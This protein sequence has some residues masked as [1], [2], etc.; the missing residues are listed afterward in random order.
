M[1]VLSSLKVRWLGSALTGAAFLSGFMAAA[2]ATAQQ[3]VAAVDTV[4]L[5]GSEGIETVTVTARRK[6][7]NEHNVPISLTALEANT[8]Q[9]NG[10]ANA[11]KLTELV[12]SLQ[13]VS[14]NARNTNISV[15][16]L[17]SNI[18]LANDGIEGGV[19][20]YV[21]G[22]FYPR[23][24]EATFDFPDI[25]S[26]EEL[27]GP[28]G[29]LYGKNTT[30]GA[31]NITTLAPTVD[32]EFLGSASV[33]DWSYGKIDGTVSGS[34]S[35]DDTLLGR[36]TA[37]ETTRNG[38]LQNVTTGSRSFDY[39]DYGLRGQTVWQPNSDFKL[40]IIADY[41]KQRQECCITVLQNFVSTLDDGQAVPWNFYQR[42]A[43]AGYTPLPIDPFARKTD[44]N[45][46]YHEFMEQGGLSA[47][48]DWTRNGYTFTSISAFRF[49]NWNPD[50][51]SDIT[52]LSV[53]DTARQA[54]QEDEF[55]QEFR[56]QSPTSDVFEY[57]AG[58]YYFWE[59]D[60]GSG[61]QIYGN[62]APVWLVHTSTDQDW[63]YALQNVGIFSKSDPR[64]NSY[65]AYGQAVWHVTPNI[66]LTGGVRYT[67]EEKTGS[68][69]QNVGGGVDISTL[70]PDEQATILAHRAA[71][72][73]VAFPYYQVR[74]D[75][76]E[77]SGLVT[78]SYKFDDDL[79]AYATYSH[80]AKSGGL[81]LS[82]LPPGV[83]NVVQP[84][85]E[86]N[87]E[88]GF[89]SILLDH[90][91]VLNADAFWDEDTDYQATII[92][93]VN[94]II[95]NYIS[96]IPSVRSRGLEADLHAQVTEDL[97]AYASGA[98]T[99]AVN[100][101]YPDAPCPFEDYTVSSSGALVTNGTCNL[102]GSRLAAVSKWAF[103]F[104]GE[105]DHSLSSLGWGPWTGYLGA[106]VSYRSSYYSSADDSRYGLVPGYTLTNLR[107]GV[108]SDDAHWNLEA[109]ARNAF[110]TKYY[111]TIGKVAFNTGA[112]SALLGDPRTVGVTLRLK[113]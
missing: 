10:I 61:Q 92:Q 109:W 102:N 85:F 79:N 71:V 60:K 24:A 72:G 59:D 19:G 106:D 107:L 113:Y 91:L 39:H 105:Y 1:R 68:Y 42:S 73:L 87:Y 5:T 99:D 70:P 108:R 30:S 51:D 93:Q 33:G 47:Q 82:V 40:R 38:F 14:F 11:L 35:G 44:A 37:S 56:I 55:T 41:N 67:Y 25:A 78:A 23:P 50:N 34:L 32:P 94:G 69:F 97:S 20:V 89:K 83:P 62:D 6:A 86:D 46:P 101:K 75:K 8:L 112:F 100:M 27:R 21:D 9:N 45:S 98:Y 18:G 16:G 77:P 52:A 13:I 4:T 31:I 22:V 28:Q 53:L 64:I 58:L 74:E 63:N 43:Q 54:D 81:N 17:G 110:D 57:S 95:S 15:R 90:H 7:E 29:T 104:G 48:A 66:D 111:Q 65:A 12:P 49:W 36:F 76:G 84:E 2:P 80:G 96:N 103:S 26:I 88:I 3:Q